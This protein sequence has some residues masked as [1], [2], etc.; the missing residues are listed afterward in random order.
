M[1]ISETKSSGANGMQ[2]F[3]PVKAAKAILLSKLK[4]AKV[5]VDA[6]CGNGY[7]TL[8][9][10]QNTPL[11]AEIL[12]F[13]IQESAIKATERLLL[14]ED[15]LYKVKLH[16][17]SHANIQHYLNGAGI[18]AAMFNLGYLPGDDHNIVTKTTST[19]L[20][21]K[22][23]MEALNAGGVLSIAAYP[24]HQEGARE[25]NEL[26]TFLAALPYKS[27]NIIRLEMLN[28][29]NN[30]PVLYMLEKVKRR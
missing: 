17:E 22:A 28:H 12:A 29:I 24:G 23:V 18:D 30:P 16:H 27:F 5:A 2:T 8:F 25:E 7:D 14:Q 26:H 3:N 15:L 20:A 4:T 13:D 1:K 21:V 6:T 19:M 11:E 9:L 10:A